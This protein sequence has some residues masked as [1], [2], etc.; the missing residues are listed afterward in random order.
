MT[1][2]YQPKSFEHLLGLKGFSDQLLKSHF[3]LYQGYV[4]NTNRLAET[5]MG[6]LKEGRTGT[7]EYAELKR[8][9]GWEF[10]GMRLHEYYFGNMSQGD[11]ELENSSELYRRIVEDFGSYE[12]LG[13]GLQ[14]DRHD[15]WNR[16]GCAL[17]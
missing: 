13:E 4:N 3:T 8:R 10:N 2:L 5:L 12:K 11:M 9:F 7:P 16:M 1:E 17:P 14:R 6:L 15:A